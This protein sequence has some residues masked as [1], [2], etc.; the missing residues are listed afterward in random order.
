MRRIIAVLSLLVAS[1]GPQETP[2]AF[3]AENLTKGP[4][5][6]KLCTADNPDFDGFRYP[7]HLAHCKRHITNALK[8]RVA[9]AYGVPK[10]DYHLYEFDHYIPL[11]AGGANAFDN[12]WPETWDEA[13][14]KDVLELDIYNKLKA[15]EI[16]QE[17]AVAMV[18]QWRPSLRQRLF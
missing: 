14:E 18:K 9:K 16:N 17:E 1:C 4:P 8:D 10:T 2:S 13:K 5:A 11:N 3:R 15:G 12:L 6:G 7:T